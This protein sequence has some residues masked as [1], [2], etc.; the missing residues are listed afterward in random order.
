VASAAAPATVS[1]TPAAPAAFTRLRPCLVNHQRAA[2]ELF[3]IERRDG[4]LGFPIL[5]DFG[6][7][8]TARLPR[9]TI[10]KERQ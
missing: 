4:F 3:A 6:K 1:S 5:A 7:S 9:K 10:A 2:H 8:E